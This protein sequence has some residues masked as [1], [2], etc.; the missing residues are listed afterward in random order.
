MM[1]RSTLVA[2]LFATA[3]FASSSPHEANDNQRR[4]IILAGEPDIVTLMT[5]YSDDKIVPVK[6]K[7]KFAEEGRMQYAYRSK[8]GTFDHE[9]DIKFGNSDKGKKK[10]RVS[11]EIMHACRSGRHPS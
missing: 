1:L 6:G 4:S 10:I 3:T 5:S 11:T 8:D 2:V 7:G 9:F